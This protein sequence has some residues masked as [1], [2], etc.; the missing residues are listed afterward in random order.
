[1]SRDFGQDQ[2]GWF[3]STSRQ[4]GSFTS[5]THPVT[6]PGWGVACLTSR[7]SL[8]LLCT[9]GSLG[10]PHSTVVSRYLDFLPWPL[11]FRKEHCKKSKSCEIGNILKAT[12]HCSE[13][14]TGTLPTRRGG[15]MDLA[16][17]WEEWQNFEAVFN[18][19]ASFARLYVCEI[20]PHCCI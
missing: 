10:H 6:R 8:Q 3:C 12:S 16:F 19:Q 15:E 20:H 18:P 14:V 17:Q 1:M 7:S 2:A 4:L 11:A 9:G 13:M 5:R